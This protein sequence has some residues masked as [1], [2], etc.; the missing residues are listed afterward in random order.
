MTRTALWEQ[1]RD[2]VGV[3]SPVSGHHDVIVVG[4]GLTGLATA[5]LLAESGRS[6]LV[7]EAR[8]A[9]AGATGRSTAKVSALQG[10]R[11]SSIRS[12]HGDDVARHYAVAQLEGLAWLRTFCE[13]HGVPAE[14]RA[15]VSYATSARGAADVEAEHAAALAAGLGTELVP[16]PGL[17]F[18]VTRAVRLAGQLQLDPM[19]LVEAMVDE[20]RRMGVTFATMTRVRSVRSGSPCQVLTETGTGTAGTVVMATN[21]PILDRGGHFARMK[22]VRSYLLAFRSQRPLGLEDMSVS[23]DGPTRSLRDAGHRDQ[24]YLLVGGEG[25]VTGRDGRPSQRLQA[26]RS[27]TGEHFPG[28]TE[29][30]AWSAQDYLPAHDLPLV[31]P[32]VPDSER[33]LMAGGYS[34]WGFTNAVAAAIALR[35]GVTGEATEW[36]D[37]MRSWSRAELR[38]VGRMALDNAQVGFE[39]T[40]GWLAP[41]THLGGSPEEGE[42]IVRA[43][44]LGPPTAISRVEGHERRVS[45][46]CTHLGGI[47][48][49][50]DAEHSWDCPLHGSRFAP[51]GTVL[52]GPATCGLREL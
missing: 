2:P 26:L 48:R 4:A 34:K 23:V 35:D 10:V 39:M 32:L 21:L 45:A 30:H 19:A 43:D 37:A 5:L 31:G 40:R 42:G 7:V 47:V 50:N 15:A 8:H 6:V 9:G 13:Q 12:R 41:V 29:T 11:L 44:R 20:G 16:D 24:H 49:W 27:W 14:E 3:P 33:L 51:D 28:L 38:G 52:E 36:G 17:P 25:H 46:V 22:P 18:P 1:D